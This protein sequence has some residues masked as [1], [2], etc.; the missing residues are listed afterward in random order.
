ML[1]GTIVKN[2]SNL[3]TVLVDNKTYDCTPR[4]KFRNIKLTPF[5][6]DE[7]V[8][9]EENNY[10][11]EVMDRKNVIS[12]P[13]VS[14]V[15]VMLIVT[16]LK[17]PSL[18]ILLLDKEISLSYISKIE[19]VICFTKSDLL[20]YEELESLV[21][22]S[23]SETFNRNMW[24]SITTIVSVVALLCV[25]LNDIFT[26]NVAILIGL[27]AG[28]IS[29]LLIGPRFWMILERRSMNKPEEEDDEPRELKVKGINS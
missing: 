11:L 2:I 10:I 17:E 13:S 22:E 18:S 26:F 9:D 7:V 6:G 1:K 3:Y 8:I 28:T 5:V 27:I 19:P 15:D 25:G 4:G 16:A 29:S 12:R 24:T 20:S 14:N 23:S 21:N